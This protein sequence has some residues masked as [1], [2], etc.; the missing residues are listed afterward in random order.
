[1]AACY[2][3]HDRM[4]PG[5]FSG[6]TP[7]YSSLES[8]ADTYSSGGTSYPGRGHLVLGPCTCVGGGGGGGGTAS[9]ISV[10]FPSTQS[11]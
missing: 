4:M 5:L 11:I 8:G 7:S 2:S 6:P 10:G 9:P 1:M 3:L